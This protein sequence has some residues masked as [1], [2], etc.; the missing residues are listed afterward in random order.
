MHNERITPIL[1]ARVR[2]IRQLVLSDTCP[3]SGKRVYGAIYLHGSAIGIGQDDAVFR[4]FPSDHDVV[5]TDLCIRVERG[6]DYVAFLHYPGFETDGHPGLCC[7]VGVDLSHDT[8]LYRP[9]RGRRSV[10]ILHRKELLVGCDHPLYETFSGL[11]AAEDR[12]GLLEDRKRIGW[13]LIWEAQ[14]RNRGLRIVG[15]QI[16]AL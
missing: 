14:L 2:S 3:I 11:T 7:S 1:I 16:E 15:H 10:P 9:F 5:A 12:L 13:S 4:L 8:A 6:R